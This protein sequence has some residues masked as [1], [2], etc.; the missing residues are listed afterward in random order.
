MSLGGKYALVMGS[1]RGIGRGPRFGR[2]TALKVGSKGSSSCENMADLFR[3]THIGLNDKTI[4]P[5]LAD[6][7]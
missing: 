6:F 2:G 7:R 1:S 3:V 4:R 5:I